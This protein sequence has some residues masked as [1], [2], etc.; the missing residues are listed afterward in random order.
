MPRPRRN[1]S[2]DFKAK[3]AMAALRGDQTLAE[4]V[5]YYE[6]HANQIQELEEAIA[7]ERGEGLS[8]LSFNRFLL[9]LSHRRPPLRCS[10]VLKVVSL[11]RGYYNFN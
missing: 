11:A 8:G 5:G 6:V 10:Y 2:P 3:V 7:R 1:H 9:F 4:L